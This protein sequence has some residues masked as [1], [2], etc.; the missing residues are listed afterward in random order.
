MQDEDVDDPFEER[1]QR[2]HHHGRD[3]VGHVSVAEDDRTVKA[4]ARVA[5][6]IDGEGYFQNSRQH[7][8]VRNPCGPC[9][10]HWLSLSWLI[11][12]PVDGCHQGCGR[13][14]QQLLRGMSGH[15][16]IAGRDRFSETA[17]RLGAADLVRHHCGQGRKR[18]LVRGAK[19][20]VHEPE[21]DGIGAVDDVIPE[22]QRMALP[23]YRVVLSDELS[24]ASSS[25]RA[26]CGPRRVAANSATFGP[27]CRR[28]SRML[29][30]TEK[31]SW[32]AAVSRLSASRIAG[33]ETPST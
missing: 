4:A 19:S 12:H 1:E 27:L 24:S 8:P 23:F 5:P 14:F 15:A 32:P 20:V 28:V 3:R 33:R 10:P 26:S 17:I 9:A 18:R 29:W 25:G 30:A 6:I 31:S 2:D 11:L 7:C 22:C 13:G 16:R 21:C